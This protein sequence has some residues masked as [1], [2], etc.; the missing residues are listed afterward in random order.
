MAA[1]VSVTTVSDAL[2]GKGR[3]PEPTRLKV[4]AVADQ[5]NYR[6]SAMALSLRDRGLGMIGICVAPAGDASLTEV[7]Y[8][9]AIVTHASQTILSE[10]LL[11]VM[12]P[13][14]VELLTKLKVPLDGVILVDPL[15]DDPVLSFFESNKTRCVT[16]GRDLGRYNGIWVDDDNEVGIAR[17]LDLTTER[18]AK[19]AFITAGPKKS[20]IVDAIDG[21]TRWA[22]SNDASLSVYPCESLEL[23]HAAA[24]VDRAISEGASVLITQT[25]RLALRVLSVLQTRNLKLPHDVKLLSAADGPELERTSPTISALRQHPGA[26]ADMAA[27]ALLAQIRGM[28]AAKTGKLPMELVLRQSAPAIAR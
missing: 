16:I 20:Y 17:L 24:T 14:K 4:Q 15:V 5:L 9:A 10:G 21:A 1:G 18:G 12:L 19:L 2:S 3:L 11:P 8:W 7:G 25:E 13:H 23:A 22:R 6:P 28:S 27:N 26:L